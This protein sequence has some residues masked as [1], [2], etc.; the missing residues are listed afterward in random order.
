MGNVMQRAGQ[1]AYKDMNDRLTTELAETMLD[2]KKAAQ[3]MQAAKTNPKL[4][5]MIEALR[6]SGAVVG[7][8]AP[9]VYQSNVK[10]KD[11]N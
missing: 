2:P 7:T 8:A 4:K 1:I 5:A 10:P 9:S 3:L 6:T 11:R